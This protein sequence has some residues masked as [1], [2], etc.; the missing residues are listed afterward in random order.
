M[1]PPW[2]MAGSW[3]IALLEAC[4][5]LGKVR[6]D[7]R[8]LLGVVGV[9]GDDLLQPA[10][11]GFLENMGRGVKVKGH[12]FRPFCRHF[13]LSF[14]HGGVIAVVACAVVMIHRCHG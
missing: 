11:R 3:E 10:F 14:C 9:V 1:S 8:D 4:R 5:F 7:Q 13:C 6:A 2:I 12:Y